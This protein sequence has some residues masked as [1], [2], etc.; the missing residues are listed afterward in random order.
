MRIVVNSLLV[1]SLGIH[2]SISVTALPSLNYPPQ[3]R[4]QQGYQSQATSTL[5]MGSLRSEALHCS[6]QGLSATNGRL[7]LLLPNRASF[8]LLFHGLQHCL[9]LK[10]L[11]AYGLT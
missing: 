5:Q 11:L 10:V 3:V 6:G 7:R 8:S 2:H 4:T 1:P 9:R